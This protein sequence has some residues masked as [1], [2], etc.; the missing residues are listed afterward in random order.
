MIVDPRD[1]TAAGLAKVAPACGEC[2]DGGEVVLAQG[3]EMYPQRPDLWVHDN[4]D[5]RWMWRCARCD[6]YCGVHRG[7]ITPLGTP[8]GK[9]TREA[10]SAAHAAFDP[11]W[12]KR[13]HLSA[14]K[15]S[16]ARAKGYRWLAGELGINP[17]EC[18]IGMMDAAMC[19]RVI[20][21]CSRRR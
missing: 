14:M 8:A 3:R 9:A 5:E 18:H 6:A 20:E 11:L 1:F 16:R 7:T 21:I 2:A 15:P 10:R 13:A 4:G 17:K 12:Q 19:R